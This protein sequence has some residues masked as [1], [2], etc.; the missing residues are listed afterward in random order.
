MSLEAK[1]PIPEGYGLL[2]VQGQGRVVGIMVYGLKGPPKA[3]FI[4][5]NY[6]GVIMEFAISSPAGLNVS[7]IPFSS[8]LDNP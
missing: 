2:Q 1:V 5:L 4:H 6:P 3:L 7:G 8:V